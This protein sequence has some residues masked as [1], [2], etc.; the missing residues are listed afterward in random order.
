MKT[1]G[2]RWRGAGARAWRTSPSRQERRHHHRRH[3]SDG[4]RPPAD[5]RVDSSRI[6]VE[7]LLP[8]EPGPARPVRLVRPARLSVTQVLVA[9]GVRRRRR[10]RRRWCCAAGSTSTRRLSRASPHRAR[11]DRADFADVDGA[12]A[13]RRVQLGDVHDVCRRGRKAEVLRCRAGRR[14]RRRVLGAPSAAPQVLRSTRVPIVGRRRS[15]RRGQ[16]QL[17]R[18]RCRPPTCGPPWPKCAIPAPRP[19]RELGQ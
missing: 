8:R 12:V 18:A 5:R 9:V 15:R 17:R 2:R 10:R 7:R 6:F 4:A 11:L 1:L 13:G 19:S 3:R 14:R 16:G